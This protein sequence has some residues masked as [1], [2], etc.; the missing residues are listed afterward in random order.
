M[1]RTKQAVGKRKTKSEKQS[2]RITEATYPELLVLDWVE[3]SVGEKG[4]LV[5][6]RTV[7]G[8]KRPLV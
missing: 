3:S 5:V 7:R 1:P 8:L 2:T 4:R 6:L